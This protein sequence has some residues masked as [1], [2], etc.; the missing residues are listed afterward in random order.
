LRLGSILAAWNDHDVGSRSSLGLN[1]GG[2]VRLGIEVVK[3]V[4]K[5]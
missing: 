1:I 5:Q 4:E 3:N 2:L